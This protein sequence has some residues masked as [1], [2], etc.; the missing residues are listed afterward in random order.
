MHDCITE[1][2]RG[3]EFSTFTFTKRVSSKVA[4]VYTRDARNGDLRQ[5]VQHYDY[6]THSLAA[7][8]LVSLA[9]VGWLA[10]AN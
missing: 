3:S 9:G 7:C 4:I 1:K 5:V 6:G 8:G 2:F 10:R